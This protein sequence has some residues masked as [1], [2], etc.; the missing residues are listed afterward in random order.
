[1]PLW[2]SKEITPSRAR[3]SSSSATLSFGGRITPGATSGI[4]TLTLNGAN[5]GANTIS[6]VLA[7]HDA[8][9]LAVTKSGSGVWILSGA[10]TYSGDTTVSGGTLKFNITSGTP[11][12]AA[13]VTATVASGATLEMAGSVSALGTAGGNRVHIV[14]NSTALRPRRLRHEPSRGRHRRFG[15][16]AMSTPAA[17]S[18]PI[19]SFKAS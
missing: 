8:G 15:H 19:T 16:S 10:N 18:R 5:T 11:T 3:A 7:D 13:G 9:K 14:N 12:I 17:I 4:T 6:G 1:M 2:C